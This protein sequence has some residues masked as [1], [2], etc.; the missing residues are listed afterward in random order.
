MSCS[1][2]V[3]TKDYNFNPKIINRRKYK[4]FT[5]KKYSSELNTNNNVKQNP[6]I[7]ICIGIWGIKIMY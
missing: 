6:L 5:I 7:T 1:F 3:N 4:R 2:I